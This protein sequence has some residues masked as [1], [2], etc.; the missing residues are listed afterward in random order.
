MLYMLNLMLHV[1][2]IS[3]RLKQ[4]NKIKNIKTHQDHFPQERNSFL[5]FV[6]IFI[7]ARNMSNYS[8][9]GFHQQSSC[10]NTGLSKWALEPVLPSYCCCNKVPQTWWLPTTEIYSHTVLEARSWGPKSR[11]GRAVL[12]P[13]PLGRIFASSSFWWPQE[14]LGLWLHHSVSVSCFL[15]CVSLCP[16]FL[17]PLRMPVTL[18]LEST[19]IHYGHILTWPHLQRPYFQTRSHSW[20]GINFVGTYPTQ[21]RVHF[22]I[23]HRSIWPQRT[24]TP[25]SARCMPLT[26]SRVVHH[27][28]PINTKQI[29]S[30][31]LSGQF[32]SRRSRRGLGI[33]SRAAHVMGSSQFW[34]PLLQKN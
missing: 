6:W 23:Q 32:W 28:H 22:M 27:S 16:N 30:Q 2:S 8:Q 15:L 25:V 24:Q 18:D 10:Q 26:I 17:L 1:N 12:P 3:I 29:H 14:F 5:R 33:C 11:S 34:E 19:L 13:K 21:Y 9:N 20:V 4:K 31:N 7:N